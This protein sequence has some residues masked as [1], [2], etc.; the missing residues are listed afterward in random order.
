MAHRLAPR[1]RRT[2]VL[3]LILA[4][5]AISELVSYSRVIEATP[6]LHWWDRLG[7]LP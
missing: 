4:L 5:T 1:S 3:G 2:A 6:L 7:R